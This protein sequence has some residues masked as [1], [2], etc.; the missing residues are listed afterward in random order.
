MTTQTKSLDFSRFVASVG[1]RALAAMFLVYFSPIMI[2]VAALIRLDS[3]GPVLSRQ[4]RRG[5][6]GEMISLLEFR[7]VVEEGEGIGRITSQTVIGAFLY[8][9]RLDLLPRLINMLRGEVS[10]NGLLR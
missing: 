5:L 10:F 8:E 7:T 3:N 2:V 9:T 1:N 6:N 4:S